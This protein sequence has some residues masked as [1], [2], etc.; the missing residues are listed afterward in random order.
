MR[1][2]QIVIVFLV[3]SS[4]VYWQWTPNG[5]LAAG[6]AILAAIFISALMIALGRLLARL[7]VGKPLRGEQK[8][9]TALRQQSGD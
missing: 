6:L 7:V 2:L 8:T 3:L 1:L 9:P 5:Y 4:N